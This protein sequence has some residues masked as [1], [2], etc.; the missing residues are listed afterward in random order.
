MVGSRAAT[1]KHLFRFCVHV[2]VPPDVSGFAHCHGW[3]TFV[4]QLGSVPQS[5]TPAL[6]SESLHFVA[7]LPLPLQVAG[8]VAHV[9]EQACRLPSA[10]V[11]VDS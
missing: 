9:E 1:G 7:A 5:R 6:V 4:T 10:A 8:V 3:T 2:H 11:Q